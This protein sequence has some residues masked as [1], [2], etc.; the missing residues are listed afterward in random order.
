MK[1]E[2]KTK[3]ELIREL[4]SCNDKIRILEGFI[5][6]YSKPKKELKITK[7][8]LRILNRELEE[9]NTQ[10]SN[11]IRISELKYQRLFE[12]ANF[13]KDLF[14]HDILNI[15]NAI[16]LAADMISFD[17]N[18]PK[19][20]KKKVQLIKT[21][22]K[23]GVKLISNVRKLFEIDQSKIPL[24][25]INAYKVLK[26]VINLIKKTYL[27]KVINIE[28]EPIDEKIIVKANDLLFDVFENIIINAIKYTNHS[29][30]EILI[31]ISKFTYQERKYFKFEFIDNGMG[32]PDKKK[33]KIFKAGFRG[34]KSTRGMGLGLSL[35]KNII[36]SYK[37]KTWVED[38]IK[39]NFSKG[40]NFVV[41]IPEND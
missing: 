13:Y 28:L 38:R 30:I 17:L 10:I 8:N 12:K 4:N 35:V 39:G 16:L 1:D 9:L 11:G 26:E 37:G 40:S 6:K 19:R 25:E 15:L 23:R 33:D 24:K 5:K 22:I 20:I 31:R 27:S 14:T 3:E 29:V 7:K 36:L 41:L 2:D 18:N 21:H 32:I 34:K